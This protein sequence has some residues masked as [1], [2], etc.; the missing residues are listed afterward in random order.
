MEVREYLRQAVEATA[1]HPRRA[2][3]SS[4]GVFWGSAAIVLLLAWGSGFRSYM[5]SELQRYGR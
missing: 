1:S 2:I 5:Y 4:M 3:A